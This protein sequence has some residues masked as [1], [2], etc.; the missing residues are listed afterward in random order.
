M[1]GCLVAAAVALAS[2]GLLI[3]NHARAGPTSLL[4]RIW[5]RVWDDGKKQEDT[6]GGQR[7]MVLAA[8]EA[9]KKKE[10]LLLLNT[11]M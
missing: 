8:A 9:R 7:K 11:R 1:N 4:S 5:K 3:A 2:A 10:V 6:P